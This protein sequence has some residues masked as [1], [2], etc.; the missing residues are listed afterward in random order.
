MKTRKSFECRRG[1]PKYMYED[2]R[3][4][5]DRVLTLAKMKASLHFS[6]HRSEYMR[7]FRQYV[8]RRFRCKPSAVRF[9]ALP[10]SLCRIRRASLDET[11]DCYGGAD[12][13]DIR[14]SKNMHMGFD[15]LVGTLVHE[16][17]HCFCKARG[18][19]L[20]AEIEHHCMRVL[21]D[22]C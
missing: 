22:D 3:L 15:E 14:I 10:V 13:Q 16:E 4:V 7:V 17:L 2:C 1:F 21:G 5:D 19:F 20:G 9:D 8:C 11:D 12:G 18:R 6:V